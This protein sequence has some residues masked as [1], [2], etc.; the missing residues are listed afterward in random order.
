[1]SGIRRF[2]AFLVDAAKN[3]PRVQFEKE[4]YA[5]RKPRSAG[6]KRTAARKAGGTGAGTRKKSTGGAK[7]KR[8][9]Q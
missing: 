8:K 7:G 9:A 3:G 5:K 1:M 6:A 4:E 2:S